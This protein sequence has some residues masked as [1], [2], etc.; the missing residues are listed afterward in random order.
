LDAFKEFLGI[1]E[2]LQDDSECVFHFLTPASMMIWLFYFSDPA[3]N[4]LLGVLAP[5]THRVINIQTIQVGFHL[6]AHAGDMNINHG[7]L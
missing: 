4:S 2:K 7:R 6:G 3:P 5:S 1:F